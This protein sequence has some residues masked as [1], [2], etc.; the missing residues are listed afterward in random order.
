MTIPGF[1]DFQGAPQWRGLPLLGPTSLLIPAG[2]QTTVA[3]PVGNFAGVHVFVSSA[4]IGLTVTVTFAVDAAMTQVVD[5]VAYPLPT[6]MVL[7]EVIPC[8]GDFVTVNINPAGGA[9]GSV[10]VAIVATNLGV[11]RWLSLSENPELLKVNASQPANTVTTFPL[12]ALTAAPAFVHVNPHGAGGQLQF[13]LY[14]LFPGGGLNKLLRAYGGPVAAVT[15]QVILPAAPVG[16]QVN[17]TDAAAPH[18]Y[19]LAVVPQ[20]AL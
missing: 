1:P 8:I 16:M 14:T 2:G 19:D 4:V 13:T 7:S 12:A 6:P 15:E 11:G 17:N 20:L 3:F 5:S 10:N 9:G 18:V